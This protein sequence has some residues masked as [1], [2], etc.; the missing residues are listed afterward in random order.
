MLERLFGY[1]YEHSKVEVWKMRKNLAN[2]LAGAVFIL[3]IVILV[4][5]NFATTGG[6]FDWNQ[7]W[8]HE[9][10]AVLC[11]V[12]SIFLLVGRYVRK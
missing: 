2:I 4:H 8:H 11:F 6:W 10:L 3:G 1:D 12:S 7:F 5:Q 9:P